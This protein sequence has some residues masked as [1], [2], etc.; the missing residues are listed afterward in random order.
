MSIL[1]NAFE[2]MISDG[3]L[4]ARVDYSELVSQKSGFL[5]CSKEKLSAH[6]SVSAPLLVRCVFANSSIDERV[7][8]QECYASSTL[9][10]LFYSSIGFS[11]R[12]KT[13][14]ILTIFRLCISVNTEMTSWYR[15]LVYALNVCYYVFYR[16]WMSHLCKRAKRAMSRLKNQVCEKRENC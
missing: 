15:G 9:L 12:P 2:V 1:G 11:R 14:F 10:L 16:K 6:C 3:V 7:K 5:N 8:E 4:W 13:N